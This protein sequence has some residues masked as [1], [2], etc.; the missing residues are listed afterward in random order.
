MFM[1]S[2]IRRFGSGKKKINVLF[3]ELFHCSFLIQLRCCREERSEWKQ[4]KCHLFEH[5]MCCTFAFIS[6]RPTVA[7]VIAC[8]LLFFSS[9]FGLSRRC[10]RCLITWFQPGRGS[11]L[12]EKAEFRTERQQI[13]IHCLSLWFHPSRQMK[14]WHFTFSANHRYMHN[15]KLNSLTTQCAETESTM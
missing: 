7:T 14:R 15:F 12:G 5:S 11:R 3:P 4:F 10:S 8:C 1:H 9:F 13:F 2:G 6:S